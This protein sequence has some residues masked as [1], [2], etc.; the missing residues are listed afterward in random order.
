VTTNPE[1]A[2]SHPAPAGSK[3]QPPPAIEAE[4][5][6]YAGDDLS[7][8]YSISHGEYLI[9]RDKG[10]QI[11]VEIEGVSRHHARLTFQGYELVIEDLGS[12]NGVFIEG[13]QVQLPTRV[14]P[15]QQVEVGDARIFIRL[16][17]EASEMLAAA[18]WDPDLGLAPV[19][20]LLNG[21][22]YK[23]M[24]SIG[25]GGMGVV[26]QARD[27]R[28]H[29]TVAMK[30]IKTASQFSR[31]NVLRFV[32]EAQLTGQLQHPNIVPVYEIALDDQDEVFYT[33]KYVKGITL[34][35]VLK[36]LRKG[37]PA[38]VT[39]YSLTALLDIFQKICDGVAFAHSKGVVH[40]DLKPDNIMIGE[41]GE[42]LVMDWGLAKRM[43][44]GMHDEHLSDAAPRAP[45]AAVEMPPA[46]LREFQTLNGLIVG[47][48]P[49]I[50]PEAARGELDQMSPQSDIYVLGS[51]LYAILTLRPPYPG[52]EFGELIEQIVSG[53]FEHPSSFN[54]SPRGS[55]G[56]PDN[57]AYV[58]AHLPGRRVPEGLAAIVLKAMSYK[59]EDRYV[60][61]EELQ[62]DI[63]AWQNGFAP[64]AERAGLRKQVTLWAAR[65]KDKVAFFTAFAV[66][67]HAAVIWFF[68][69]LKSQRDIAQRN[70]Q[71]AI[72]KQRQLDIALNDLQG[73]GP[74]FFKEAKDL[75]QKRDFESAL[76]R[77]DTALRQL[78][79]NAE[80]HNLRGNVCQTLLRLDDAEDSYQR[81]LELNA[82]FPNAKENL[83][84]TQKLLSESNEDH[85][86]EPKHI[87]ELEKA[88]VSQKRL[89]EAA[90]V[91]E[92]SGLEPGMFFRNLRAAIE[93]NPE[94]QP[95]RDVIGEKREFRNRFTKQADGTWSAM[96]HRVPQSTYVPLLKAG[97][98]KISILNLNESSIKDLAPLAGLKDLRSLSLLDCKGV[99]DLSPIAGL[100]LQTLTIARTN[101]SDLT[102]LSRMPLRELRLDGCARISDLKPLAALKNLKS[103]TLPMLRRG[104]DVEFLRDMTSIEFIGF[105]DPLMPAAEF[106][107]TYDE[108]AKK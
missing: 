81:V 56:A 103:L 102:P 24:G 92:K 60:M 10:C 26:H 93:T 94:L 9:G 87:K 34:D 31:E 20:A 18:L 14:R 3:L 1:S 52:K 77:L 44:S 99:T 2:N 32:D 28:I 17:A 55:V 108:K 21:K 59:V 98:A 89:A 45:E 72:E 75:V 39:E 48:P 12:S 86:L 88:L 25:R 6:V 46:G 74:I 106:W 104:A 64:K 62:D 47:T 85:E 58:L 7:A 40:R 53:K 42:V 65:H 80:Y 71:I 67:F 30:V 100:P 8:K 82:G 43:S 96:L 22:K 16:K 61:V 97:V 91:A 76:D 73:T 107:K 37:D 4:V 84:L 90:S 57:I 105:K 27:L 41:Y 35:D 68:L 13:I 36:G 19:R 49:Y 78:P 51:I 50:S 70:E 69:S 29:R 66:I 83:A 23:V 63:T 38:M 95:L 54:A 5:L 33:M 79:N 101:V 11:C 15:D